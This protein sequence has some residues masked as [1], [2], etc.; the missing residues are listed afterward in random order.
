VTDT[1]SAVDGERHALTRRR[2]LDAALELVDSEGLKA[3]SMRRLGAALGVEAMSLYHHFSSKG[4]L[5]DGLVATVLNEVPLPEATPTGWADAVRYGF[6]AFRRIL[7]AHPEL[8]PLIANRPPVQRETLVVVARA[9]AILEAAGFEPR[10]AG[11]AWTTLLSY[12]FGFVL[13]EITGMG[14]ATRGDAMLAI[15]RE[16]FGPDLAAL[17]NLHLVLDPWDGDWEF[18]QGL[19]VVIAGLRGRLGVGAG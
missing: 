13:C 5:L 8:F 18:A 19:D 2:I 3:L 17:R 1:T 15:L 4:E 11:A 12:T 9:F 6:G 10:Q 7:L 16:H 14:E